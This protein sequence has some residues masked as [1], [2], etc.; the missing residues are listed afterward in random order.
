MAGLLAKGQLS[1]GTWIYKEMPSVGGLSKGSL[2]IFK[3][4]SEKTTQNSERLGQQVT[5]DWAWHLP[6][7]NFLEQNRSATCGAQE[8]DSGIFEKL[9]WSIFK[10]G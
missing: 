1:A 4:V 10:S 2:P 8:F 9:S 5:E 6:S 3:R 7:T